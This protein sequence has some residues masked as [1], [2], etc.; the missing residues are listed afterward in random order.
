MNTYF[1]HR[2]A[3]MYTWYRD[4]LGQKS[5]IDF[6]IVSSELR[7]AVMDV[8]FKRG[9]EL[10]TDHHLVTGKLRL[11]EK[12]LPRMIKI[13][14]LKRIKWEELS[15]EEVREKFASSL[16]TRLNQVELDDSDAEAVW[17]VFKLGIQASAAESCG[18]KYIGPAPN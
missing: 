8:R 4:T 10:S 1:R 17:K 14:R 6:M 2:K 15:T 7:V 12:L 16:S 9:A 13:N 5:I 11:S 3:H 18:T